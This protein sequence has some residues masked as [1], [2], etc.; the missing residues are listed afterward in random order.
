MS[1]KQKNSISQESNMSL[2][3][4]LDILHGMRDMCI[5]CDFDKG[6]IAFETVFEWIDRMVSVFYKIGE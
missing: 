6:V 1:E 3:E 5:K 2:S 4:A